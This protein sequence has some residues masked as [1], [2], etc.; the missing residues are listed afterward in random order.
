[1]IFVSTLYFYTQKAETAAKRDTAVYETDTLTFLKSLFEWKHPERSTYFGEKVCITLLRQ[2]KIGEKSDSPP[3]KQIWIPTYIAHKD[4]KH[5]TYADN[6]EYIA[7]L[8][9]ALSDTQKEG[10]YNI[11]IAFNTF[12]YNSKE[13]RYTR[14]QGQAL[15]SQAIAIDLDFYHMDAFQGLTYEQAIAKIKA[16]HAEIFKKYSPMIVRS[17]GGCQLYFLNC[18]PILFFDGNDKEAPQVSE[19]ARTFQGLSKYFNDQFL[20]AG[21]D[22]KCKGDAARIFKIPGV[23][24]LKYENPIKVALT[25][26]GRPHS[27]RGIEIPLEVEKPSKRPQKPQEPHREQ[28]K[29]TQKTKKSPNFS[30]FVP[31][32]VSN[33]LVEYDK[34]Y[35]NIVNRRIQDLDTILNSVKNMTGFREIYLFVYAILLSSH[36]NMNSIKSILY[37]KNE[38]FSEPLPMEEIENIIRQVFKKPYKVT[39]DYIYRTLLEPLHIDLELLR[40]NYTNEAKAEANRARFNKHYEKR[41][42]KA[43][44]KQD[45]VD[46]ISNHPGMSN[47]ELAETL[48]CSKRTIERLKRAV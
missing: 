41:A 16:D 14:T 47:Q 3:V 4:G 34:P 37:S 25:A 30:S 32:D 40:G 5:W 33:S 48:K 28:P 44:S 45:K 43:Y 2:V 24:S 7:R 22:K 11:F 39:N 27:F 12:R 15:R 23:Y 26:P 36:E 21:A 38:M 35:E 1:M 10:N 6:F 29:D 18:R 9:K 42:V 20:D 19:H 13:K 46:F 8:I 17:G 31:V